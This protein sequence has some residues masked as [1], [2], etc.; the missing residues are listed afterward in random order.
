MSHKDDASNTAGVIAKPERADAANGRVSS[1]YGI[2][3][4]TT[5]CQPL[6]TADDA[7]F[8]VPHFLKSWLNLGNKSQKAKITDMTT[9]FICHFTCD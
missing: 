4:D 7:V 1:R 9:E 2:T 6:Y 5:A 8:G 3:C